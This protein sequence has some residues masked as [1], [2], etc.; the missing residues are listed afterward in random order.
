MPPTGGGGG[1]GKPAILW[2]PPNN[3]GAGLAAA[4][5]NTQVI[6][7]NVVS[8]LTFSHIA[9]FITTADGVNNND[10]GVYNQAGTQLIANV[11]A[12]HMASTGWQGFATLQGA[13]TIPAGLYVFAFTSVGSTFAIGQNAVLLTWCGPSSSGGASVGGA[14]P[15]TVTVPAFTLSGNSGLNFQLY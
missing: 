13:V 3:V 10:L 6:G 11:G 7:F 8:P 14:L 12:Q 15:S 2:Q 4:A 1:G 9:P 5:N